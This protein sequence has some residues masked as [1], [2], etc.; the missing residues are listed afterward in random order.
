MKSVS[1]KKQAQ[2]AA[3]VARDEAELALIQM[4]SMGLTN[5]RGRDGVRRS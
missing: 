5:P 1:D 4:T 2:R 3:R